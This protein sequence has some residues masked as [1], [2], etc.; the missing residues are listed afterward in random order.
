MELWLKLSQFTCGNQYLTHDVK[1]PAAGK[2]RPCHGARRKMGCTE[3]RQ[4]NAQGK[5]LGSGLVPRSVRRKSLKAYSLYYNIC[6]A[7]KRH[8]SLTALV[9]SKKNFKGALNK[10]G[11][12]QWSM[13]SLGT[14][15]CTQQVGDMQAIQSLHRLLF[16]ECPSADRGW[17]FTGGLSALNTLTQL[18]AHLLCKHNGQHLEPDEIN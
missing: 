2:G 8:P 3:V 9:F 10:L 15:E 1:V 12:E 18:W 16:P 14:L 6:L 11:A 7:S 13:T 5:G 4:V 17:C